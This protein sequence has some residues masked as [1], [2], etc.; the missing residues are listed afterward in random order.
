MKALVFLTLLLLLPQAVPVTG[1]G[2]TQGRRGNALYNQQQYE[3]AS[4]AYATGLT[5]YQEDQ[6]DAAYYG[7]QNNLGAALR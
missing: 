6:V 4:G 5:A 2:K 7:L 3:E 1:G